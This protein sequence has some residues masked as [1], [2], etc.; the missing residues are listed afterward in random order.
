MNETWT[1]VVLQNQLEPSWH[2]NK[3]SVVKKDV[4]L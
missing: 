2:E 1:L 3:K 4:E